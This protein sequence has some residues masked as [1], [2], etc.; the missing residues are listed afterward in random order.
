MFGLA[1]S[2][3]RPFYRCL[4]FKDLTSRQVSDN[5]C[6]SFVFPQLTMNKQY[7]KGNTIV[8][9]EEGDSVLQEQQ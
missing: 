5:P 1:R 2:L 8:V 6:P 7:R 4:S 9:E 3:A